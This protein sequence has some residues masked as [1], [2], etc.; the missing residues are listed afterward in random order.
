M[1]KITRSTVDLNINEMRRAIDNFIHWA[2]ENGYVLPEATLNDDGTMTFNDDQNNEAFH[3]AE[4]ETSKE[5][6]I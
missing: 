6:W 4:I 3:Q 5:E 1:I 2:A